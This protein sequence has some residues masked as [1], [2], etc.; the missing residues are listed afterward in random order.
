MYSKSRGDDWAEDHAGFPSSRVRHR[1]WQLRP[2]MQTLRKG[3][4]TL[5]LAPQIYES[6]QKE[7]VT[8]TPSDPLRLFGGH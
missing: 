3:Q 2:A 1:T 8:A 6:L 7:K 4:K 5:K